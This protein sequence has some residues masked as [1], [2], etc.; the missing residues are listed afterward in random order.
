[1]TSRSRSC[2]PRTGT[3]RLLLLLLLVTSSTAAA[4]G[5]EGDDVGEVKRVLLQHAE[6]V[7]QGNLVLLDSLWAHDE[8]VTVFEG[9]RA[10]YGWKDYRDRHLRPE[11]ERM[12]NVKYRLS[13]INPNIEGKIAWV[14]F[15]Y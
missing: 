8:R 2:G 1:M 10:D 15:K 9:G 4:Q 11:L 12:K 3:V 14:T 7:E 13:D 5:G 6:G